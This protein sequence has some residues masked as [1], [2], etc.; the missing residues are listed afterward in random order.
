MHCL[1][2]RDRSGFGVFL[3]LITP[4]ECGVTTVSAPFIRQACALLVLA[5]ALVRINV[6]SAIALAPRVWE[7][8][9]ACVQ[10]PKVSIHQVR[11]ATAAP[12]I[13]AS[14]NVMSTGVSFSICRVRTI[15]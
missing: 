9:L 12:S 8:F 13:L 1:W 2:Q 6:G 11:P 14:I 5:H 3:A 15:K 10:L 7:L 4:A